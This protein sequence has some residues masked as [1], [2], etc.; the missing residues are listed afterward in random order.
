MIKLISTTHLCA[1]QGPTVE[2]GKAIVYGME[3]IE[4]P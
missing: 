4:K 1:A 2:A 3:M